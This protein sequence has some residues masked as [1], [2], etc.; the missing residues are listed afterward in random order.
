MTSMPSST[1]TMC[2]SAV[3]ETLLGGACP[4]CLLGDVMSGPED[5]KAEDFDG[6]ELLGE[7]AR[8]GMGVVYRARQLEP[9]RLVALKTLRS[10]SLDS[11]EAMA[12]F[13]HEAE[14]MVALDHPAILP[15]H[16]C[17]EMDGIPFFTMKLVEGGTLS[18]RIDRYAG[19]WREIAE[20]MSRVCDGVR[21][22]HERGVLHRDL[23]PGNIL[24]DAAGQAYVSD[25]GIAKLADSQHAGL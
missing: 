10:A 20:L 5:A 21:H 9:E 15:V 19:Q 3:D 18:D 6:H 13:K 11:P 12:R 1:C 23:K 14:V 8:G 25:F 7:I 16:H 22:A 17:G 4:R 2:G 24:F